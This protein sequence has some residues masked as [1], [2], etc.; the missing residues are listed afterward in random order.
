MTRTSRQGEG[1]GGVAES[2]RGSPPRHGK[3]AGSSWPASMH[4]RMSENTA[5]T[6]A[7]RKL[8]KTQPADL[9][10]ATAFMKHVP[11]TTSCPSPLQKF[12]GFRL[13][14]QDGPSPTIPD[15]QPTQ[16]NFRL[17]QATSEKFKQNIDIAQSNFSSIPGYIRVILI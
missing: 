17:Y 3:L 9:L 10:Q 16:S 2:A 12:F 8:Q 6:T 14:A 7:N 1:L 5:T 4:T 15:V 11:T 13:H